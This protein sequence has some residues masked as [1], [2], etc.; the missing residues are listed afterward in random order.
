MEA[1][2]F[3]MLSLHFFVTPVSVGFLHG[4]V[5][6]IFDSAAAFSLV[7]RNFISTYWLHVQ[8]HPEKYLSQPLISYHLKYFNNTMVKRIILHPPIL[9]M[10]KIGQAMQCPINSKLVLPL[11]KVWPP[12]LEQ[13]AHRIRPDR[14]V[15]AGH[16]LANHD[17]TVELSR[18]RINSTSIRIVLIRLLY[19]YF[20][21]DQAIN[22]YTFISYSPGPIPRPSPCLED[23][24]SRGH[25][26]MQPTCELKY[27]LHYIQTECDP[28]DHTFIKRPEHCRQCKKFRS[29]YRRSTTLGVPSSVSKCMICWAVWSFGEMSGGV[30]KLVGLGVFEAGVDVVKVVE[31]EVSS[32]ALL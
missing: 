1:R 14:W 17:R 2:F 11:V 28:Q 6:Q 15:R 21:L 22:N 18:H 10:S 4:V 7:S 3:P 29:S 23:L 5:D 12:P 30:E 24:K 25:K 19:I 9:V 13:Q 31:V 16:L 20:K 26:N 27:N 8:M 32:A